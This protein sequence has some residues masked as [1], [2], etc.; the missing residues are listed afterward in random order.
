M[1]QIFHLHFVLIVWDIFFSRWYHFVVYEQMNLLMFAF[2]HFVLVIVRPSYRWP[3]LICWF[4]VFEPKAIWCRKWNH[5]W[6]FCRAKSFKY[7]FLNVSVGFRLDLFVSNSDQLLFACVCCL[8][9]DFLAIDQWHIRLVL[10][11]LI[12]RCSS[13]SKGCNHLSNH[14]SNW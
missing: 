13:S 12:H 10:E 8:L 1:A 2:V 14:E 7:W 9:V 4:V 3:S 5:C 6:S 11:R